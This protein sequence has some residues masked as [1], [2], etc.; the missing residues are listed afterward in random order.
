MF[1]PT[2]IEVPTNIPLTE[3]QGWKIPILDQG[4]EGACT[5]FGLA[6]VANYLLTRRKVI[7][8]PTPVSPRMFYEIAKRYDE[9]PGENYD[10]SSARG[11]M[12]G[13]HKHGVCSESE[14]PC[15][16][17]KAAT[18]FLSS[19]RATLSRIL[20]VNH[21]GHAQVRFHRMASSQ[22]DRRNHLMMQSR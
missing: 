1:E 14:W 8:D 5:G 11:A 18:D 20:N 13:W 21:A 9:W 7:P 3:Y 22:H 2:L 6:T 16:A 15:K 12:K 19:A 17:K 4:Q 10:G